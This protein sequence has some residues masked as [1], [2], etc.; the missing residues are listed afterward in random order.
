MAHVAWTK[1]G[2]AD[3]AVIEGDRVQLRSS[4]AAAPGTPLE[5]SL[6]GGSGK[7][8]RVK[9]ARCR[10]D[11]P[12]GV[13]IIEGRLVDASR[14]LRSELSALVGATAAREDAGE[15]NQ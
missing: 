3:L 5:G 7:R 13:F 10:R 8:F 6:Q 4:V 11:E 2:E 15:G 9:V 14:D 12:A 1:G